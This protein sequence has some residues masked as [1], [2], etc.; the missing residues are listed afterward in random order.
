M[1]QMFFFQGFKQKAMD[2][3]DLRFQFPGFWA[4]LRYPIKKVPPRDSEGRFFLV[5]L[6][7]T[8]G[9]P[10]LSPGLKTSFLPGGTSGGVL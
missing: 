9:F 2:V 4:L 1:S 10:F 5:G 7:E 6:R 8:I 3:M